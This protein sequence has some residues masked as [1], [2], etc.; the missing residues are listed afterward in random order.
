[1]IPS[2]ESGSSPGPA[3]IPDPRRG[4]SRSPRQQRLAPR[5]STLRTRAVALLQQHGGS[6]W[7]RSQSAGQPRIAKRSQDWT[8]ATPWLVYNA[9]RGTELLNRFGG[10]DTCRHNHF[11]RPWCLVHSTNH[12]DEPRAH[13]AAELGVS[14]TSLIGPPLKTCAMHKVVGY[15]RYEET[16][17]SSGRHGRFCRVGPGN[18]TPSR[19]QGASPR[20]QMSE[21]CRPRHLIGFREVFW[22][23]STRCSASTLQSVDTPAAC[24][25][26]GW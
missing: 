18:F 1:V 7:D 9:T 12:G 3:A 11:V 21:V 14:P 6:S 25:L 2:H 15:P 5:R 26:R 22:I 8:P 24:A 20:L 4:S 13:R 17:R 19:S 23:D 16:C 10:H